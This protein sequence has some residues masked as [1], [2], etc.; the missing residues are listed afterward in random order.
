MREKEQRYLDTLGESLE[1][2]PMSLLL[3]LYCLV[4]LSGFSNLLNLLG[5]IGIVLYYDDVF[6]I[7][8]GL[9]YG[10]SNSTLGVTYST[11]RL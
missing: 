2:R 1:L 5:S 6:L 3:F 11:G 4:S 10:V 7:L 9:I 8:F